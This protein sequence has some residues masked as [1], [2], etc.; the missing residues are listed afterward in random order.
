MMSINIAGTVFECQSCH[1][2]CNVAGV[3]AADMKIELHENAADNSNF[4][5]GRIFG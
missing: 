1:F 3:E 2:R 5:L 4:M